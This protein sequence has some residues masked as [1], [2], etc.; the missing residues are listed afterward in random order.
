MVVLPV[1]DILVFMSGAFRHILPTAS[2][3]FDH[4]LTQ[5]V[6]GLSSIMPTMTGPI[7]KFIQK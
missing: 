4:K 3:E 2:N 1:R 5:L 6:K 7:N